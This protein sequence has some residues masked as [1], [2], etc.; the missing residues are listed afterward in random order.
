[1]NKEKQIEE[2]AQVRCGQQDCKKCNPRNNFCQHKAEVEKYYLAGYRKASEVAEEVIRKME[3]I[4]EVKIIGIEEDFFHGTA[5]H[6]DATRKNCYEE[7]LDELAELK[8][9]YT[10]EK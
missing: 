6:W 7:I 2:M 8:K 9:K 4:V 3:Q 5:S 10:Q 1:M